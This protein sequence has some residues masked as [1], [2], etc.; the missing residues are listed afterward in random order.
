MPLLYHTVPLQ[1]LYC[2]TLPLMYHY[3]TLSVPLRYY[4]I[5]NVP[6]LYP[7]CAI[8]APLLYPFCN[9]NLLL[10]PY[11]AP[12]AP[13]RQFFCFYYF[14]ILS[15]YAAPSTTPLVPSYY[16][17]LTLVSSP[18]RCVL[19]GSNFPCSRSGNQC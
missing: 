14:S 18:L 15:V 7:Y 16:L 1:Y 9:P 4:C 11:C 17:D 19:L 12:T 10:H 13:Q 8:T 6:L 5:P 2:T 3:C